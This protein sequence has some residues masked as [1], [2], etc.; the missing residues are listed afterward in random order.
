MSTTNKQKNDL[1][2]RKMEREAFL[3]NREI[4]KETKSKSDYNLRRGNNNSDNKL[5]N[6]TK[7]RNQPRSPSKNSREGGIMNIGSTSRRAGEKPSAED[8]SDVI[9]SKSNKFSSGETVLV[10]RSRGG[11]EFHFLSFF[12]V[13]F[14]LFS[15][16]SNEVLYMDK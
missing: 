14:Y 2:Q 9:F 6:N 5:N 1:E 8:L 13:Y 11:F 4:E 10:L 3:L 12:N 7:T 15:S 16:S